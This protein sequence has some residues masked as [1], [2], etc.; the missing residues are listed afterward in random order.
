MT[1]TTPAIDG[2]A[3][4]KADWRGRLRRADRVLVASAA[5]LLALLATAP[6]Q[7]VASLGFLARALASIAP[8]LAVS[9]LVAGWAKATG[10]DQQIAR[11]FQGRETG[12]ILAAAGLGALSPFCSCGVI[13]LI[14]GL[15][16]AG[17]P[18]APVMAFWLASPLM[19]PNQFALLVGAIGLEFALAKTLAAI[20]IGLFGGFGTLA[21]VGAGGLADP[22]RPAVGRPSAC[23]A[24]RSLKPPAPV[25]RF[26]TEPERAQVFVLESGRSAWFLL[27]WLS[28]AFLIESLMVVWLPGEA[29]A[30]LLGE[31]N[32]FAI[33]LAVALGVPAYLNGFAAIPLVSGLIGL[34]MSPAVGLTFMLAGGVTSIPAAMAVWALVKPRVFAAYLAFAASGA[35]AAGYGYMAVLAWA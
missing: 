29:V 32:A 7:A 16:A 10:A 14:A 31:G 3:P 12:A 26:W 19:D 33:P 18:I 20:G 34:G 9:V 15:L 2:A 13:P 21:I 4:P 11:A 35:L 23:R 5:L 8:F 22:L 6:A 28:L 25:W 17:V 30:R 1:T 24:K 27:R